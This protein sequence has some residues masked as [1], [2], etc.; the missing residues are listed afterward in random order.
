MRSTAGYRTAHIKQPGVAVC[1]H[2]VR[3]AVV[4]T[5]RIESAHLCKEALLV[6][7][8]A[9]RQLCKGDAGHM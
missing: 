9:P 2:D 3:T 6:L 8:H 7:Q 4:G 5:P 1:L